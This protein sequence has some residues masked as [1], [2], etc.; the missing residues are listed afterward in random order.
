MH[1][2]L[3]HYATTT[4]CRLSRSNFN[5]NLKKVNSSVVVVVVVVVVVAAGRLGRCVFR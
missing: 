4:D 5:F 1:N 3:K 2:S